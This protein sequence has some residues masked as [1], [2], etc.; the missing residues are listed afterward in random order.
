MTAFEKLIYSVLTACIS[1]DAGLVIFLFGGFVLCGIFFVLFLTPWFREVPHRFFVAAGAAIPVI[2][3]VYAGVF[4]LLVSG[5][6]PSIMLA[7]S[8]V[9]LAFVP[10]VFSL[11]CT[12]KHKTIENRTRIIVALSCT[13]LAQLWATLVLWLATN[14]NFMG[15]GC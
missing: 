5:R 3:L 12:A 9:L 2:V 10:S 11:V 15:A 14:Y 6:E 4:G 1:S 13:I 8:P 7:L